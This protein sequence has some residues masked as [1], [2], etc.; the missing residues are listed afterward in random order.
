MGTMRRASRVLEELH[1]DRD[2]DAAS[3][4]EKPSRRDQS[5]RRRGLQAT[6]GTEGES[7]TSTPF[8]GSF[9]PCAGRRPARAGPHRENC[10]EVGV[11]CIPECSENLP[12][13]QK[14][15]MERPYR[16]SA[17][18]VATVQQPGRY[19]DG[20]GSGGLPLRVKRTARGHLAK[21]WGQRISMD[22]RPRNLGLG[23]WPHV[24]LAEARQK[25]VLNLLARQRGELVTG[26]R[27]TIPTFAEAVEKVLAV[28]AAGWKD[29]S[30][31]LRSPV[32]RH[33]VVVGERQ[34]VLFAA[35]VVPMA[36]RRTC[37][38]RCC[39]FLPLLLRVGLAVPDPATRCPRRWYTFLPLPRSTRGFRPFRMCCQ[40]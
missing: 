17:R 34:R 5:R 23:T 21:S 9:G 1:E 8:R 29:G 14:P 11:L 35:V 39:T 37:V 38:R 22:G 40:R 12:R 6:P 27:R 20:R 25:C 4:P 26:R 16:L 33:A 7:A 3:S 36:A 30:A 2:A 31:V 10:P 32:G 15:I 18:F 28:H 13:N 24:S 19:D